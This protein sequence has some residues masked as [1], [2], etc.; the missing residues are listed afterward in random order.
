MLAFNGIGGAPRFN[1]TVFK[2]STTMS[3]NAQMDTGVPI[4]GCLQ[5]KTNAQVTAATYWYLPSNLGLD[6]TFGKPSVSS[7]ISLPHAIPWP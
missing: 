6:C 7:L 5:C 3:A 4:L 1:R 2:C